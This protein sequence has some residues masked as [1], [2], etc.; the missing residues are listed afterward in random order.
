[1]ADQI[2]GPELNGELIGASSRGEIVVVFQP[3]FDLADRSIRAVELLAR[4]QHPRLG[5]L[6]PG[7]FIPLAEASGAI[8]GLGLFMLDRACRCSAAWNLAGHGIEV[9]V[10]VSPLQLESPEFF[11]RLR[12]NL[13]LPGFE[14]TLVTL[15]LTESHPL[16]DAH[17][18]ALRL[19]ELRTMGF[20][21]SIDDF[22][23][24]YSDM[25]RLLELPVNELK[26]DRSIILDAELGGR[27]PMAELVATAKAKGLR[28]VAEGIETAAQLRLAGAL[29]CDRAQGFLLSMPVSEE[30]ITEL[31][32][33]GR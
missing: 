28:V 31:L 33:R 22:G 14:P 17:T 20:G 15:E 8:D 1:M 21:V 2:S 6:A 3:Q 25:A 26:L 23:Q 32:K 24:G 27:Q 5:V 12:S 16:T 19:Q 18:T 7:D 30:E 9:A 4:W 13:E 29:G 10:N 11:S